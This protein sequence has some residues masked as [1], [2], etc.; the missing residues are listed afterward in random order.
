VNG[1]RVEGEPTP[2][3]FMAVQ[4]TW[5][6][7]DRMELELHMPFHLEAIDTENPN[8]VALMYGPLALFAVGDLPSRITRAQLLAATQSSEDFVVQADSTSFA[9]RP[10][11]AI[12]DETYRLY[13]QVAG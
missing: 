7:G 1:K 2:G 13:Q 8:T 11:S 12:M 6:D 9:L 4:R 3:K 10:F 5:K